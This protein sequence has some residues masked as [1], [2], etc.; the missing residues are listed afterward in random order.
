MSADFHDLLTQIERAALDTTTRWRNGLELQLQRAANQTNRDP[1][2]QADYDRVRKQVIEQRTQVFYDTL[3]QIRADI[4]NGALKELREFERQRNELAILGEH[5]SSLN[6]KIGDLQKDWN[7]QEDI[8]QLRTDAARAISLY[9]TEVEDG[10][11]F[12]LAAD[13]Y[14]SPLLTRI[15]TIRQQV[16]DPRSVENMLADVRKMIKRADKTRISTLA[17]LGNYEAIIKELEAIPDDDYLEIVKDE[18]GATHGT[19]KREDAIYRYHALAEA[20]AGKKADLYRREAELALLDG[21]IYEANTQIQE[22]LILYG[23]HGGKKGELQKFYDENIQPLLNCIKFARKQLGAVMSA[24]SLNDALNFYN[25]ALSESDGW[26]AFAGLDIRSDQG[27]IDPKAQPPSAL[28]SAAA[29]HIES[30]MN[31]FLSVRLK[32]VD[33]PKQMARISVVISPEEMKKIT[34]Y[35]EWGRGQLQIKYSEQFNKLKNAYS[36]QI[37]QRTGVETASAAA[38]QLIT[39]RKY[40]DAHHALEGYASILEQNADLYPIEITVWNRVK[41]LNNL[42]QIKIDVSTTLDRGYDITALDAEIARF[43]QLQTTIKTAFEVNKEGAVAVGLSQEDVDATHL[44]W[45]LRGFKL[46]DTGKLEDAQKMWGNIPSTSRYY[47]D[48]ETLLKDVGKRIRVDDDLDKAIVDGR[49]LFTANRF[50]Q[51]YAVLIVHQDKTDARGYGDFRVLFDDVCQAYG[52]HLLTQ[53]KQNVETPPGDST[54]LE[55]WKAKLEEVLPA[56]YQEN[57]RWITIAHLQQVAEEV[58]RLARPTQNPELWRK[59]LQNCSA[60]NTLS[61]QPEWLAEI[62]ELYTDALVNQALNESSTQNDDLEQAAAPLDGV[63]FPAI[64][65]LALNVSKSPLIPLLRA[66]TYNRYIH[67]GDTPTHVQRY[68]Q[69]V[70]IELNKLK[71]SSD[72]FAIDVNYLAKQLSEANALILLANQL[73]TTLVLEKSFSEWKTVIQKWDAVQV[74][75]QPYLGMM[76]WAH[77]RFNE[78]REL[79]QQ[80]VPENLVV[81]LENLARLSL[82]GQHTMD[83]WSL[84]ERL[85]NEARLA[86]DG[87]ETTNV[88]QYKQ[89]E[90]GAWS[91]AYLINPTAESPLA[92]DI[93]MESFSINAD[94]IYDQEEFAVQVAT[95]LHKR[96]SMAGNFKNILGRAQGK[97]NTAKTTGEFTPVKEEMDHIL[98]GD[99]QIFANTSEFRKLKRELDAVKTTHERLSSLL[100]AINRC[101]TNEQFNLVPDLLDEL[102]KQPQSADDPTGGDGLHPSDLAKASDPF[103]E[104]EILYGTTQIRQRAQE[105]QA[106]ITALTDWLSP[107]IAQ[108]DLYAQIQIHINEDEPKTNPTIDFSSVSLVDF[109]VVDAQIGSERANAQY[110]G[111]LELL[112]KVDVGVGGTQESPRYYDPSLT[113]YSLTQAYS[114][115]QNSP[116]KGRD[117]KSATARAIFKWAGILYHEIRAQL[118]QA[119][120]RYEDLEQA[121][122]EFTRLFPQLIDDINAMMSTK[123]SGRKQA[124]VAIEATYGKLVSGKDSAGNSI[125]FPVTTPNGYYTLYP[126]AAT[127]QPAIE[128][129]QDAQ[130]YR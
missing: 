36:D 50:D 83:T 99:L 80:N 53:I 32:I 63:A 127:Y 118:K 28:V 29:S 48:V 56:L 107:L 61:P 128:L 3:E 126:V 24:A 119:V 79:I 8:R 15:E 122:Q 18:A 25:S 101:F 52:S 70:Q 73:D 51:A 125:L 77:K 104:D 12:Q 10:K 105:K 55:K 88:L 34:Q 35:V 130:R 91:L 43:E 19:F 1:E 20:F 37:N 124:F 49:D 68:V 100:T 117:L 22:A 115:L 72:R 106:H 6:A 96:A 71:D 38:Q 129:Y 13:T 7:L 82:L 62:W 69:S 30:M 89:L 5:D 112:T 58:Y 103:A 121:H 75:L 21:R 54:V 109:S 111:A 2:R 59:A 17:G 46:R 66:R 120:E 27:E 4:K 14:L 95:A 86:F 16:D 11:D 76:M 57:E 47:P 60:L 90:R 114:H 123:G 64:N 31:N 78:A 85:R 67:L 97:L 108:D 113:L 94:P 42:S 65:N 45:L 33:D 110:E 44:L 84:L 23:L 92:S 74:Q 93:E 87:T 39:E 98:E 41:A 116:L 81:E 102:E 9:K 26:P 40:V